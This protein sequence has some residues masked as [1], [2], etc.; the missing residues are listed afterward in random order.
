MMVPTSPCRVGRRAGL[1]R[2]CREEAASRVENLGG[3]H[4]SGS[5]LRLTQVTHAVPLA[6][7]HTHTLRQK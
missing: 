2:H 5:L 7:G 1:Y 3:E 4:F 6:R